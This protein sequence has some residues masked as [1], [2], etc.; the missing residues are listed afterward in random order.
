MSPTDAADPLMAVLPPDVTVSVLPLVALPPSVLFPPAVTEIAPGAVIVPPNEAL[1][2]AFAVTVVPAC[3][4]PVSPMSCPAVI[5]TASFDEAT[6]P[7]PV[8]EPDCEL[9]VT[10]PCAWAVP[11]SVVPCAE[12][13]VSAPLPV[14]LPETFA[15]PACAMIAVSPTPDTAPLM[16]ALRAAVRS[17]V[18]PPLTAPFTVRSRPAFAA[19]VPGAVS[20]ELTVMSP[21]V[22]LSERFWPET[23]P[24]VIELP[25]VSV[26]LP[27]AATDAALR[28]PPAES[29]ASC[30]ADALPVTLMSPVA[31]TV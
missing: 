21:V 12:E 27:L 17:T 20:P 6:L 11:P 31:E 23:E 8:T 28:L 30:P 9:I 16:A 24:T 15:V 13:T 22:V 18:L 7:L 4:E 19:I 25:A 26:L 1:R 3:T 29:V 14:A 5:E 2:P 10:G